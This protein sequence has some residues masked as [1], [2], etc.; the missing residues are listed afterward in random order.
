[1]HN[2][3]DK[4]ITNLLHSGNKKDLIKAMGLHNKKKPEDKKVKPLN[5]MGKAL[6]MIAKQHTAA[7]NDTQRSVTK[8]KSIEEEYGLIVGNENAEK[9]EW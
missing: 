9:E 8:G 3:E 6:G 7:A 5:I 2:Y 4:G 1:V